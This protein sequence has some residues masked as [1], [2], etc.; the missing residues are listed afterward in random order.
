MIWSTLLIFSCLF[1]GIYTLIGSINGLSY[2]FML[3]WIPLGILSSAAILALWILFL[4]Y[5]IM[6]RCKTGSKLMQKL[7]RPIVCFVNDL[8]RIHITVEGKENI[9]DKDTFVIFAN[10][11]SM[12]DITVLYQA[13]NKPISAIAK[14]ELSEI[15]VLKT[16]SKSLR[17]QFVDRENDREAVKSLLEAIKYVKE[18]LNYFIFPEGGIKSRET[19]LVVDLKPGA[20]KLA[21][22]PRAVI[23]PVSII[24]SSKLADNSFKKRTDVKVIFHKPIYPE[25]YE[26][27]N[28]H[29][30]GEHVGGIINEGIKNA[31]K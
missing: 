9:P 1:S 12:L 6:P 21:T 28:T 31:T 26:T 19:E 16:M 13:V 22:K 10:H 14:K 17:V 4:I 5:V 3:L 29:E 24:G 8:A 25:E 2:F 18:G 11:K 15:P 30:I 27:F 20:Y 23:L 7:V